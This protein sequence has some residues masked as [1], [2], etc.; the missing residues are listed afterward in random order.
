MCASRVQTQ[1]EYCRVHKDGK[2]GGDEECAQAIER[3]PTRADRL[4]RMASQR[5]SCHKS[6]LACVSH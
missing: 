1:P 4:V 5:G 2:E 6:F 3:A